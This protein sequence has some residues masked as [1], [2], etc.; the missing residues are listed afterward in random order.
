MQ[1]DDPVTLGDGT[2]VPPNPYGIPFVQPQTLGLPTPPVLQGDGGF[3]LRRKI[4]AYL[5][6]FDSNLAPVVGQQITLTAT[7]ASS[8]GPR[9]DLFEAQAA[10][11]ACDLVA[12]SG[13]IRGIDA[14]FLFDP[15]S[16]RWQPNSASL[17]AITEAQLRGLVLKGAL[18][19]LTFTCV[20]LGEGTRVALDRD[21]DGWADADEVLARKDSAD[22]N[23]HP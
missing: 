10:A 22:P 3:E 11:G 19:S 16:G 23:S 18:P 1:T 21:G 9:I 13:S 7:A 15:A 14:G 20:P 8:A 2:V 17:P 5:M 6:A 4:V 12:K